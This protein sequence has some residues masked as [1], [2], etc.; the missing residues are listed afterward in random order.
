MQQ[1][2]SLSF[3]LQSHLLLMNRWEFK[4][5]NSQKYISNLLCLFGCFD[6]WLHAFYSLLLLMITHKNI[7]IMLQTSH[8][9]FIM[10]AQADCCMSDIHFVNLLFRPRGRKVIHSSNVQSKQKHVLRLHK[11]KTWDTLDTGSSTFDFHLTSRDVQHKNIHIIHIFLKTL[12]SFLTMLYI[13]WQQIM[14]IK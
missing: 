5:K 1:D 14:P 11:V 13:V 3:F 12:T 4:L 2:A 6:C 7:L 8:K 10:S 9:V